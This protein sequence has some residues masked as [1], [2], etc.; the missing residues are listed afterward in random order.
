MP[1]PTTPPEPPSKIRTL[2]P[3]CEGR[4]EF[5]VP[6]AAFIDGESGTAPEVKACRVCAGEGWLDG[7]QAPV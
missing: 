7:L 1:T 4:R 2:C 5:V 3:N 6:R